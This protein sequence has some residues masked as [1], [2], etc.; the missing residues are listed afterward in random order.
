ML[1]REKFGSTQEN[2][3]PMSFDF[4]RVFD[5]EA[6]QQDVYSEIA[7][8]CL[9]VLDGYKICLMAGLKGKTRSLLETSI[10]PSAPIATR[11]RFK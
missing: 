1:H 4:D 10:T 8:V 6:R 7:D 3:G 11:P 9:G 5:P 2:L